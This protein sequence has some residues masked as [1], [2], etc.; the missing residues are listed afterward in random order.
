[1]RFEKEQAGMRETTIDSLI[2]QQRALHSL[3]DLLSGNTTVFI[4]NHGRGALATASFRGTAATHTRVTWNGMEISSP[5]TGM[6]DFSLV[7]VYLI[8]KLTLRHGSSSIV[9][10]GGG[11]GGSINLS[12]NAS[13][14]EPFSLSYMQG[15]GSFRTFDEF[16]EVGGG[17]KRFRV[18]TRIYHGYSKNNY[19]FLNRA[20]GNIDPLSGNIIHPVDTNDHADFK[21]YGILQE[22]YFRPGKTGILSLKYW[23]QTASRTIPRATS[24]EGPDHS[25]LNSQED[26]NHKLVIGWDRYN[27]PNNLSLQTGLMRSKLNY[28]LKNLVPGLGMIPAVFATSNH[29]GSLN[30]VSFHRDF[31]KTFS[32]KASID[33]DLHRI[34]STDTVTG[35]GYKISRSTV[36]GLLSLSKTLADRLNLHFMLRQDFVD[37]EFT[38]IIPFAGFDLDLVKDNTLVFKGNISRNYRI[39]TLNDLFWQPGGNPRLLPERGIS[40]ELGLEVVINPGLFSLE[41]EITFFRSDINNWIIWIPSYKGYW[42]PNNI[43]RVVSSGLESRITVRG[44][45]GPVSFRVHATYAYTQSLNF[46]E[47]EIWGEDSFGKQLVYIPLHSGNLMVHSRYKGFYLSYQHNSYSERFTT[48]TNDVSR[49]DWLYPYFMNDISLGKDLHLKKFNLSMELKIMNLLNETY[50]SILYR[51]M[52]GRYFLVVIKVEI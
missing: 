26:R 45:S 29:L 18:K 4:K 52:P 1:M 16:L 51:P 50:H 37:N 34:N 33:M 22:L 6:V 10:Q 11:I 5:M 28:S 17:N 25:N 15:L 8:D 32:I 43:S 40:G 42:E 20:R 44:M 35:A 47:P 14:D 19:T 23:G 12:N 38:P 39:P 49:R 9:D 3:S 31:N 27:G 30:K 24:Y 36:S 46:G 13:W 2:L 21:R 41:S 48:S 7:P